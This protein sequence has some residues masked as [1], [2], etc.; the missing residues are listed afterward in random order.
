MSDGPQGA[1]VLVWRRTVNDG[2][3]WL[4]LHRAHNGSDYAVNWAAFEFQ[5]GS[6]W[7]GGIGA[8]DNT[9]TFPTLTGLPTTNQIVFGV[10]GKG[11]SSSADHSGSA[12][13]NTPWVEDVDLNTLFNV[14]DGVY[15]TVGHQI[16]TS[17]TS[18]TPVATIAAV[19]VKVPSASGRALLVHERARS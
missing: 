10:L 2:R 7:T 4:I 13:W 11:L 6:T 8:S 12:T 16:N 9:K 15:L 14:T 18:V 3:E 17:T 1:A 19:T 5:S